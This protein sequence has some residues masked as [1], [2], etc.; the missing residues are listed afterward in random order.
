[1]RVVAFR[2]PAPEDLRTEVI[3]VPAGSDLELDLRLESVLEGILV[4][5]SVRAV[6][7]GECARCLEPLERPIE[8]DL[9][10]LFAYPGHE[11]EDA[12]RVDEIGRAHV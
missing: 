5:G 2:E 8:V 4:S 12:S 6:A 11:S 10:E 7:V 1:M 9:Q 3:G